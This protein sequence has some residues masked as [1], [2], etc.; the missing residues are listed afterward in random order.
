MNSLLRL[1]QNASVGIV[2]LL[3]INLLF[4]VAR[5]VFGADGFNLFSIVAGFLV[6]ASATGLW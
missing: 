5:N 3:W 2:A 4:I 6:V 1:R